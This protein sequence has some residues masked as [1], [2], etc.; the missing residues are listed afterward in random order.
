MQCQPFN[1][2][3]AQKLHYTQKSKY[4][5]RLTVVLRDKEV[6]KQGNVFNKW[7]SVPAYILV[8]I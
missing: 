5:E 8:D 3:H 6:V 7:L 4:K 2:V 1:A